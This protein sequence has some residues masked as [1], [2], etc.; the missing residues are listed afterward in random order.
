VKSIIIESGG[1]L[2]HH[3][4]IGVKNT[5]RYNETMPALKKEMLKSIKKHVDPKNIFCVKNFFADE[6]NEENCKIVSKL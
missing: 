5:K 3:H 1:S 6:K 2:S 4:G